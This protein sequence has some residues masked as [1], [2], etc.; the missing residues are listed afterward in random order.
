MANKDERMD[1]HVV[2]VKGGGDLGTGVA[3]RLFLHHY[4]V[5]VTELPQPLVVRRTVSVASARSR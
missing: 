4:H 1:E 5:V 3:L 2:W